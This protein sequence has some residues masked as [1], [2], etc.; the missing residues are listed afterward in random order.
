METAAQ[1]RS[2]DLRQQGAARISAENPAAQERQEEVTVLP[3]R[4]YFKIC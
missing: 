4:I 1:A 2:D 3:A